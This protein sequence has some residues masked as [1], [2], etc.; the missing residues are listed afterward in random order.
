MLLAAVITGVVGLALGF[1]GGLVTYRT[2][3]R[4]CGG[5]GG[6]LA[7][8]TCNPLKPTDLAPRMNQAIP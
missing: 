6:C 8:P 4:W 7:C 1:V 2:S 3:R 5:C